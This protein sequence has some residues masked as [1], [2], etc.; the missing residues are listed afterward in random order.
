MPD[1]RSIVSGRRGWLS[2]S[3]VLRQPAQSTNAGLE[4][5]CLDSRECVV[6]GGGGSRPFAGLRSERFASPRFTSRTSAGRSGAWRPHGLLHRHGLNAH[7]RLQFTGVRLGA[8]CGAR[9]RWKRAPPVRTECPM[10]TLCRL[11]SRFRST[12]RDAATFPQTGTSCFD[13]PCS[14]GVSRARKR[15][16]RRT[17]GAGLCAAGADASLAQTLA[18]CLGT[19][20]PVWWCSDRAGARVQSPIP[21]HAVQHVP[22]QERAPVSWAKAVRLPNLGWSSCRKKSGRKEERTTN[23]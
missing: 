8:A 22:G 12:R 17:H 23:V 1:L 5:Q 2:P 14:S 10:G 6:G 4:L 11:R 20:H 9:P 13:A 7:A 3:F 21:A 16:A 19:A 15:A 18:R